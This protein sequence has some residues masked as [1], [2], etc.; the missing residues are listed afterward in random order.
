MLQLYEFAGLIQDISRTTRGNRHPVKSPELSF[1]GRCGGGPRQN[2]LVRFFDIA[3]FERVVVDYFYGMAWA[4]VK[5][6]RFV[7]M[8]PGGASANRASRLFVV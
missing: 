4:D 8:R 3:E 1:D 2:A 7:P 6:I 5:L